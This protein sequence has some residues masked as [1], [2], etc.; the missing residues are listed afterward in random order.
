MVKIEGIPKAI[1]LKRGRP[2][3]ISR[4]DAEIGRQW[5]EKQTNNKYTIV[6]N[7]FAEDYFLRKKNHE[8]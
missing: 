6:K 4:E 5:L 1:G 7:P 3:F 8:N 2:R